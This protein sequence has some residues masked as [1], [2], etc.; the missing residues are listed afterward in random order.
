MATVFHAYDSISAA[1]AC[2][3][4]GGIRFN[5]RNTFEGFVARAEAGGVVP[6]FTRKKHA[7]SLVIRDGPINGAV[8]V[9]DYGM[10]L[11]LVRVEG[12]P[13]IHEVVNTF[14]D[15][16]I[17][18]GNINTVF[19]APA[20]LGG[21]IAQGNNGLIHLSPAGE[22]VTRIHNDPELDAVLYKEGDLFQDRFILL[23]FYDHRG[24]AVFDTATFAMQPG[25]LAFPCDYFEVAGDLIFGATC[26]GIRK[27]GALRVMRARLAVGE[28]GMVAVG[29]P[30]TWELG[31]TSG[32]HPPVHD[33]DLIHCGDFTLDTLTGRVT[34]EEGVIR[35]PAGRTDFI[36]YSGDR[37]AGFTY[38]FHPREATTRK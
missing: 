33:G 36:A 26:P 6:W 7:V 32:L 2:G 13:G 3:L 14:V 12:R 23:S 27:E 20:A 15:D 35:F 17:F 22:A 8:L 38:D 4:I 11:S 16:A 1:H 9:S 5:K 28:D 21:W 34:K 25:L 29:P 31:V 10:A 19:H 30:T 37:H 24:L 18:V